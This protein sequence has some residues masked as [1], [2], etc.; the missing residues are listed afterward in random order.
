MKNLSIVINLVILLLAILLLGFLTKESEN[1]AGRDMVAVLVPT[2][3]NP[4]TGWLVYVKK[5]D[6]VEANIPIKEAVK[7]IASGG[8]IGKNGK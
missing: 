3:P 1:V 6:V 5:S 7:I 8:F 2:S 4:L